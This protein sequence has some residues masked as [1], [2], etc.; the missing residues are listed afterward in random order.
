MLRKGTAALMLALLMLAAC[1]DR[2]SE[3]LPGGSAENQDQVSGVDANDDIK[4][5][6]DKV[7]AH[8]M[9]RESARENDAVRKPA[10][11]VLFSGIKPGD[12]VLELEAMGGYYTEI[13][14]RFVG[15]DGHVI[16]QN[17]PSFDE[18][19]TPDVFRNLL[20]RDG[21]RLPNVQHIRTN[22]DTLTVADGSVDVVTWILGPHE[23]WYKGDTGDFRFG[24]PEKTFQEICRV[25]K[26]G[27][28][29]IVLDHAAAKGAPEITG[30]TTHRIDP[31]LIRTYIESAG[32][33]F[34]A[35]SD[36]LANPADEYELNVFDTLVRRD[37]DRFLQKYKK[38]N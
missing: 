15:E 9:R 29:F 32:L 33:V 30:G 5:R 19:I 22:F 38:P 18:F 25:L 20:G 17:P 31:A 35:E 10:Q 8:S 11:V 34:E 23:L 14:S 1:Q 27:G 4:A 7:L 21:E 24:D 3:T 13:L 16:M 6:I 36:I 28:T 37:T 12:R 26:P 2:P